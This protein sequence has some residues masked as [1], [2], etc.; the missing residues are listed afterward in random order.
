MNEQVTTPHAPGAPGGAH[1]IAAEAAAAAAV[2]SPEL[3]V[4]NHGDP[5]LSLSWGLTESSQDTRGQEENEAQ[6]HPEHLFPRRARLVMATS[7][8]Y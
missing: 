4:E 2:I 5:F 1:V 3:I 6:L 8:W 7:Q